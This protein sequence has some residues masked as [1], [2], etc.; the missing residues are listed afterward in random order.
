MKK[1]IF[2]LS[3]AICPFAFALGTLLRIVYQS[4]LDVLKHDLTCPTNILAAVVGDSRVETYFDPEE[5]P[6]LR[7]FG[8][9]A[10]PF[11]VT[12][13]KAKLIAELNP[14]L[15]LVIIDIW[16]DQFFSNIDKPYGP[17]VPDGIALI[18]MMTREGMAP[19]G[20]GF[21]VRVVKGVLVPGLE[22]LMAE[23]RRKGQITGGF[24][25]NHKFIKDGYFCVECAHAIPFW[26]KKTPIELPH[27]TPTGCEIVLDRLLRDLSQ[28][29]INVILTTTP[30]LWYE[31]RYTKEAREYFERRMA[32]IA[33]RHGVHWYNWMNDYQP[34]TNYWSDVNH[35]NDI[36][37]KIFS[38]DKRI[39]LGQYLK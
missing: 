26:P 17:G 14:H 7:N 37:A 33:S 8:Q 32:E 5:I 39:I 23:G 13:H 30:L 25:K 3:L 10:T 6:W 22:N 38:R 31:P 27:V 29:N 34:N 19:L 20:D 28:K 12:A 18:E 21:D 15:K 36:G 16:P 11:T 4:E 9:S 2:R 35:L 1:F 24:M